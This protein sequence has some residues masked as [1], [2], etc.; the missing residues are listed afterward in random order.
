MRDIHYPGHLPTK[1]RQLL[2][3][4][5]MWLPIVFGDIYFVSG[6]TISSR[7]CEHRG[8]DGGA[9]HSQL[10]QSSWPLTNHVLHE[11]SQVSHFHNYLLSQREDPR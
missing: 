2:G 8:G 7:F 4:D 6:N 9:H 10:R 3:S 11:V 5:G 1:E